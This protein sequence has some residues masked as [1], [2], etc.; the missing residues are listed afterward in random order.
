[1]I[2]GSWG[3][4]TWLLFILAAVMVA[5]YFGVLAPVQE[6]LEELAVTQAATHPDIAQ[7]FKGDA[8]RAD[9]YIVVF[10]FVFLSPLAL[11]MAIT[12]LIFLLSA[13]AGALAPVLGGERLAMLVLELAGA[14]A[15]YVERDV[16]MPH[17][18]Y[19]LGLFA[20]AYMV[21]SAT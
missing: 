11:F 4:S 13:L 10:M 20:R 2:F 6:R 15:L 5:S 8:G 17:A 21:I 18:L 12:V 16:W 7:S 1:M 14:A 9:A 3:W 19:F